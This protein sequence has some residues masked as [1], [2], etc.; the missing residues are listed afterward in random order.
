MQG[1]TLAYVD[2]ASRANMVKTFDGRI[3]KVKGLVGI[4]N[5]TGER[6][7]LAE[8]YYNISLIKDDKL[9]TI[10][11]RKKRSLPLKQTGK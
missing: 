10:A 4:N 1:T 5:Q 11:K 8:L 9:R 2:I 6:Q 3:W 7:H